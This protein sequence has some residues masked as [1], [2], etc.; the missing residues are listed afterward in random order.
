MHFGFTKSALLLGAALFLIGW[1][2]R[3]GEMA[4]TRAVAPVMFMLAVCVPVFIVLDLWRFYKWKRLAHPASGSLPQMPRRLLQPSR[5]AIARL[6]S[7]LR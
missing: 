5:S 4:L 7:R 6:L 1:L 3:S 2:T